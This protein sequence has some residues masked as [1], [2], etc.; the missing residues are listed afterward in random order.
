[1]KLDSKLVKSFVN[2]FTPDYTLTNAYMTKLSSCNGPITPPLCQTMFEPIINICGNN[3][4]QIP[5]SLCTDAEDGNTRNLM[6]SMTHSNERPLAEIDW[7]SFEQETQTISLFLTRTEALD[8]ERNPLQL[9]LRATD[10][11]GLSAITSISLKLHIP[12]DPKYIFKFE[13]SLSSANA[14]SN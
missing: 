8:Y 7:I 9:R 1:M 4:I 12:V 6:L 11:S 5:E 2:S 10:S 3:K 14:Y 13:Y